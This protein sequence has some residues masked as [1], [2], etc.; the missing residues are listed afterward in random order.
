MKFNDLLR[1]RQALFVAKPLA[2]SAWGMTFGAAL[3]NPSKSMAL[4][5]RKASASQVVSNMAP[6]STNR[7]A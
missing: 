3:P 2:R 7:S 5:W 4:V 6:F 1:A